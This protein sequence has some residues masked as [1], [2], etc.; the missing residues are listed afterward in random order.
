MNIKMNKIEDILNSAKLPGSIPEAHKQK[1][2][3]ELLNSPRF[4]KKKQLIWRGA[5]AFGLVA[6]MAV[7]FFFLFPVS[8]VEPSE[9]LA[10]VKNN[11][12]NIVQAGYSNNFDN[13]L[14]LFGKQGD[15]LNLR[16]EQIIDFTSDQYRLKVKDKDSKETLDDYIIKENN[17][18]RTLNPQI[19]PVNTLSKPNFIAVQKLI[20]DGQVENENTDTLHLFIKKIHDSERHQD[21]SY[22]VYNRPMR[23]NGELPAIKSE[24]ISI[25]VNREVDLD[26]YFR[27][28]PVQL[29]TEMEGTDSLEFVGSYEDEYWSEELQQLRISTPFTKSKFQSLWVSL[30]KDSITVDTNLAAVRVVLIDSLRLDSSI[31]FEADFS[32]LRELKTVSIDGNSGEIKKVKFAI[33]FDKK[34][35]DLSEIR[36][37]DHNRTPLE[38]SV[39]DYKKEKFIPAGHIRL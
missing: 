7:F 4:K 13:Q 37:V 10:K 2:K 38:N 35:I 34:K 17:L 24:P 16:V 18:Y 14:L 31:N 11:Y 6:A 15:T 25:E 28:N 23:S 27:T 36:F 9:I 12:G 32:D 5:I 21:K 30:N 1:L 33:V 29:L 3:R 22:I 26:K 8:N 19:Q 20:E 39:F